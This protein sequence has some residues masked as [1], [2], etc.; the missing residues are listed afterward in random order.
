MRVRFTNI[1]PKLRKGLF[2]L[3]TVILLIEMFVGNR[4]FNV[5]YIILRIFTQDDN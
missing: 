5:I 3:G 2:A 4:K 1:P